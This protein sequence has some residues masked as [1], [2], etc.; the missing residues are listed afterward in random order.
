MCHNKNQD[1]HNFNEKIQSTDA[2]TKMIN[3]LELSDNDFKETIVKCF[4]KK[5]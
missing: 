4:G 5:L 1:N 2:N 3:M